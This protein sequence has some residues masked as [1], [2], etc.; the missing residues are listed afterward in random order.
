MHNVLSCLFPTTVVI[1]DDSPS[2]LDSMKEA[3]SQSNVICKT[4]VNPIKALDYTND[5]SKYNT[6]DYS[7]LIRDGEESTSDWKSIL[8]NVNGLHREVYSFDR[9]TKISAVISDYMMPEING[10]DFCSNILDKN[11]QRIL[12][13]GVAEEKKVIEAFNNGYIQR[14]VR[15]GSDDFVSDVLENVNRSV[16]Q[17][18]RT[19][20][21]YISKHVS[22]GES[23]HL[24]D[25]IFANF[26]SKIF[27]SDDFVEYYMLDVFGSYILLKSDGSVKML[28]VLTE[29][30]IS[31]I[32]DTGV[33]SEEI[34]PDV[35]QK[36]QS[37]KYMIVSHSRIGLLPPV[38][39]WEKYLYPV[40]HIE[41]Y[42]TYYFTMSDAIAPDLDINEIKSF[43][44]FKKSVSV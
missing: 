28:N 5:V 39:E 3:L 41:G 35:L 11:I 8:L 25:P 31:R 22:V 26:F 33:E 17:Y 23:T 27:L 13:T 9:F 43:D 2:F 40:E 24:N 20:T 16:I 32:I 12:L 42:Q 18:F 36:L 14:F 15:K 1:V 38:S 37:R 10:V 29:S 21:D 30:E 34:D 4:F 6:L 7:N 44:A 19:Y